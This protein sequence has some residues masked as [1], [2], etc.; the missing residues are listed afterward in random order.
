MA[1][2]R[3]PNFPL[4]A[5]GSPGSRARISLKNPIGFTLIE[6]I[7]V[8]TVIGI[9]AAVSIP[10]FVSFIKVSEAR[11]AAQELVTILNQARQLAIAQNQSY[12]VDVDAAG[13]RLR[14]CPSTTTCIDTNAWKGPG[15][16]GNG[17]LKLANNVRIACTTAANLSFSSLGA[18]TPGV[19]LKVQDSQA[20]SSRYVTV[21]ASGRIQAASTGSGTCP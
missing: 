10:M 13:P 9:M 12:R 2:L 18:A 16:D 7:I 6:L 4:G 11:G 20:T 8:I 1:V 3:S 17:W 19:T 15:T 21:S 5:S 14:F